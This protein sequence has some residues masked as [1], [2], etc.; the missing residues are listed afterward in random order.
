MA[1]LQASLKVPDTRFVT[2]LAKNS[3]F[4]N[5]AKIAEALKGGTIDAVT[6]AK[7][8]QT[9]AALAAQAAVTVSVIEAAKKLPPRPSNAM[10]AAAI[11][12]ALKEDSLDPAGEPIIPTLEEQPGELPLSNPKLYRNEGTSAQA[13]VKLRGRTF[14]T[15]EDV[16]DTESYSAH[17]N[18]CTELGDIAEQSKASPGTAIFS[19]ET[20]PDKEPIPAFAFSLPVVTTVTCTANSKIVTGQNT[21]FTEDLDIGQTIVVN[22]I[23]AVIAA[24]PSDTELVLATPWSSSTQT[25]E[26]K[27]YR[28]R[29]MQE[30][31]GNYTYGDTAV[32]GRS[33]LRLGDLMVGFTSPVIEVPQIKAALLA[34]GTIGSIVP[35]TG[36]D[37]SGEECG[38]PANIPDPGIAR[39]Y[40][41]ATMDLTTD[42][43]SGL[44]VEAVV[45]GLGPEWGHIKK[46]GSQ[47]AWNGHA[48]D[49]I[50]YRS[51]T[52]LYNGKL[53]QGVDIIAAS[54]G[55]DARVAWQ[56]I[57]SPSDGEVWGGKTVTGGNTTTNPNSVAGGGGGGET[58]NSQPFS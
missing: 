19:D 35:D 50:I 32:L 55:A 30:F 46:S 12:K 40:N 58:P 41:S 17:I 10:I 21:T 38:T 24:V 28:L 44:F 3:T 57:C 34:G 33:G 6:A 20:V 45:A 16:G 25:G 36:S 2:A 37:E 18:L 15:P 39:F 27:V 56:P 7:A 13:F 8:L 11:A 26:L 14:D 4:S 51:P 9:A 1:K 31:F 52:P 54:G 49:A 47:K 48:V 53:Y 5:D 22:D 23:K 43:G 29:P 42:A